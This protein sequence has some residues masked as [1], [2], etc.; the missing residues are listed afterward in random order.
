MPKRKPKQTPEERKEALGGE[1][2]AV[3]GRLFNWR[4]GPLNES[5]EKLKTDLTSALVEFAFESLRFEIKR[6]FL[7]VKIPLDK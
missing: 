6:G 4:D 7:I 2:D 3:V 1:I 5:L